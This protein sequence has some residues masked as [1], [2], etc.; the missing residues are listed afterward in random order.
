[1]TIVQLLAVIAVLL[2]VV[3]TVLS[4]LRMLVWAA[5]TWVRCE[6][7]RGNRGTAA[8]ATVLYGVA[9]WVCAYLFFVVG[10]YL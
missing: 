4:F 1:M 7:G 2:L 9:T 5:E 6:T 10:A 8:I 3:P